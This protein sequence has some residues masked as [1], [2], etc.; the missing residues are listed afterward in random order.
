MQ[1]YVAL[2]GVNFLKASTLVFFYWRENANKIVLA[3]KTPLFG[4]TNF[5]QHVANLGVFVAHFGV[6]TA[7]FVL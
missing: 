2:P 5:E 3:F 6:F 7:K 1:R 4:A